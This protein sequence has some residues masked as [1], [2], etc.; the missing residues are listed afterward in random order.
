MA[1]G[2]RA[3]NGV[4][5]RTRTGFFQGH[6]LVRRLL[7]LQPQS[8]RRESNPHGLPLFTAGAPPLSYRTV[9]TTGGWRSI[10]PS[11][12]EPGAPGNG[13]PDGGREG[14]NPHA[15]SGRA[16]LSRARLPFR[17]RA[18]LP[19][20]G[21]N[22]GLRGQS[23]VSMPTGPTGIGRGSRSRDRTWAYGSKIRCAAA[24][25]NRDRA[26]RRSVG[27]PRV[28][29]GAVR[30][31]RA[32]G[33]PSPAATLAPSA[34]EPSL[35]PRSRSGYRSRSPAWKGGCPASGPIG[36]THCSPRRRRGEQ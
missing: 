10:S 20:E 22:L 18:M 25:T 14:S 28:E 1:T 5:D 7:Q 13:E 6:N 16:G 23:A 32:D 15:R 2:P 31:Q 30:S 34:R 19:V 24:Y 17:H 11:G 26:A 3:V 21:S 12:P 36:L 29:R 33:L 35:L 4:A 27:H 8:S 9:T